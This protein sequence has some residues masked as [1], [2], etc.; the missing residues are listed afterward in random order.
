MP[1]A[2]YVLVNPVTGRYWIITLGG[3][4]GI[5]IVQE[6]KNDFSLLVKL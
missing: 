2:M 1:L 5:S 3:V 4:D 6:C